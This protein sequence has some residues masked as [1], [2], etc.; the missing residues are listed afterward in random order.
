MTNSIFLNLDLEHSDNASSTLVVSI[1]TDNL[2]LPDEQFSK[3]YSQ[4]NEGQQHLFIFIMQ[5][6]LSCKLAEKNIQLP[7]KPFQI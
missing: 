4:L 2:L 5:Y 1:I 3:I 7:P 6:A